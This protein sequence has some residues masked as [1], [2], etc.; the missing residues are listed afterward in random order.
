[1]EVHAGP[2]AVSAVALLDTGSPQSFISE[3]VLNKMLEIGALVREDVD[4]TDTRRWSGF[5][6]SH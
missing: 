2:H 6:G 1:M 5:D 3:S 4:P